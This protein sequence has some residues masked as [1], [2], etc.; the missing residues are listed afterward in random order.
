MPSGL[1]LRLLSMPA[2]IGLNS[3]DPL[4]GYASWSILIV[5]HGLAR[6][7]EVARFR[8]RGSV[9]AISL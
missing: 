1:T 2:Q 4:S 8:A 7:V 5:S 3:S 9:A 6:S